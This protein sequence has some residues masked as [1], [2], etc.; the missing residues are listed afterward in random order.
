[1]ELK[2]ASDK[3]D[4]TL[5]CGQ[6]LAELAQEHKFTGNKFIEEGSEE[7]ADSKEGEQKDENFLKQQQDL[8]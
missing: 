6:F 8:I 4:Y 5:R 3:E 1:M 7:H 2:E